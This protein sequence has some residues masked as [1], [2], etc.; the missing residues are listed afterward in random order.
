MY[1]IA[2]I[3]KSWGLLPKILNKEKTIESRWYKNK[4]SPWDKIK[5]GDIVYFKNSGESVTIKAKVSKVLQFSDLNQKK[6]KEILNKYG[7]YIGIE[8]EKNRKFFERFKDKKYCLL[9]FLSDP[10]KIKPFNIN[11]KGFGNM[12][13]WIIIDNIKKIIRR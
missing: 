5:N 11:K 8:K 9:I 12:S 4:C 10:A 6:V 13:A 3:K 2:I 1:H 7:E